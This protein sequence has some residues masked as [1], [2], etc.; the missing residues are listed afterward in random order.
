[1]SRFS[2]TY[3]LLFLISS[4]GFAQ[5]N[6]TISGYIT[7][8]MTGESVVGAVVYD[9]NN[10]AFGTSSNV[11][12]FYS[13]SL[14]EGEH[15]IEFSFIGFKKEVKVFN[16]TENVTYDVELKTETTQLQEVEIL[17][18]APD[19]NTQSTKMST[20]ELEMEQMKTLPALMGE[21]DVLKT[22]QLL[23]GVQSAG[24][25]NSGF[26]VRGGGP[27][28]NLILLDEATVYN[29]AHL[30][31]FFSVFNADA[32]RDIEITKGGM[33]ARFGGRL[34]SV[35][36]INMKDGNMK[37][38]QFEGGIGL[39]SSRFTAQ[40]PIKVDTSSFIISARR[41]YIDV[42]M[43]P[44]LKNK[45]ELDGTGY[46]FYDLNAK[47]NHK[48]SKTDRL[49]LST[50]FGRDVFGFKDPVAGFEIDIPW[51]NAT[52]SLRWNHLFSDKLFMN[53]SLIFS[54]YQFEFA[55]VESEFEFRMFS[56]IRD[57]NVKVDF[58][59]FPNNKHEIRFG[60]NNMYHI[61]KPNNASAKV[62]EVEFQPEKT[63]LQ[64]ALEGGLY[65]QDEISFS[66]RLKGNVGLRYSWFNHIGPFQRFVKDDFDK[67]IDTLNYDSFEGLQFYQGLEPRLSMR[68]AIDEKKSIKGS[69]SQ[70]YQYVH[71][72]TLSGT[73]LPTDTWVSST[74]L[75]RPQKAIQYALGY[76]HN[77]KQNKF[78]TSV[79]LYYKDM[80]NMIEY[81]EGYVPEN[82]VNDNV[83]DYFVFGKGW[84]YGA[85][86]FVKKRTGKFT[87]WIGY[88][89][90]KTERRFK[91]IN[92]NEIFPAKYDR[93][94]DLSVVGS[95]NFN[96][97]WNLSGTFVYATGNTMTVKV[98]QA[99]IE[100]S[101]QSI[102]GPRNGYRIIPYH[103]AD[104]SLTYKQKETKKFRS[105]WN[106]SIYNV[107]NRRNP[108][109]IYE[110]K[111]GSL[112]DLSYET[113]AKMISLF[114][115]LPSI[116]WSFKF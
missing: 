37:E 44:F 18:E 74:S 56:G 78:E 43:K 82:G 105:I 16:L 17:S 102:Y 92:N 55:A 32:V 35:L 109:F 75:V 98:A 3:F 112:E 76:F 84:S 1:M 90:S 80:E 63:I 22:I 36:E 104:I 49:Y 89:I 69:Y 97:R 30:F 86:F 100:G 94:H 41:T 25:G 99:F 13:L 116:G 65:V 48:I 95:Y 113:S 91:E 66:Q 79:E 54:D 58:S 111:E 87:G 29:A 51:G 110:T 62:G 50:Y 108:Y 64:H 15:T 81:E 11:Y 39:I 96:K 73:S 21:V 12:G 31:G 4:I 114:P 9:Q 47:F 106:F 57:Y 72:A 20:I 6:Y 68:Y 24:E 7:D 5:K 14:P 103:R 2:I 33:P 83:D 52:A 67:I 53:T 61:F 77:F 10:T 93:R 23:P 8:G 59:Y 115:I 107:Y 26:Y 34:S 46:Y 45:P 38:H 42:L 71:M 28:Q 19:E 60:T 101:F 85:E 70:N 40:G 27:D 88:T